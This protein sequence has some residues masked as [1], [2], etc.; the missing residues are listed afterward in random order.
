MTIE[1]ILKTVELAVGLRVEKKMQGPFSVYDVYQIATGQKV[2]SNLMPV[3]MYSL[4]GD[5]LRKQRLGL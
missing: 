1:A 4:L 2:A 3:H 5:T